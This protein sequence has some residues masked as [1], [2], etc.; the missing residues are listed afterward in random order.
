MRDLGSLFSQ[1]TGFP[2]CGQSRGDL[3]AV[4]GITFF[5]FFK[6]IHVLLFIYL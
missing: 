5:F 3:G 6:E 1:M 2:K 4:P